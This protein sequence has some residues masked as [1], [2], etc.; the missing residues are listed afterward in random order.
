MTIDQRVKDIMGRKS[1]LGE[2]SLD[3]YFDDLAQE[4]KQ[5][6]AKLSSVTDRN[7]NFHARCKSFDEALDIA[8]SYLN[9]YACGIKM[10]KAYFGE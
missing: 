7:L 3:L 8:E 2:F 4:H 10:R 9:G 6:V 1:E 5:F